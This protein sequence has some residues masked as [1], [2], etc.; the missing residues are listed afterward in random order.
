MDSHSAYDRR[1]TPASSDF[2]S[3]MTDPVMRLQLHCIPSFQSGY[4]AEMTIT[5]RDLLQTCD[6]PRYLD[7]L[8]LHALFIVDITFVLLLVHFALLLLFGA[9]PH[10]RDFHTSLCGLLLVW[11]PP[12]VHSQVNIRYG[13]QVRT[14]VQSRTD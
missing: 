4:F 6:W 3:P 14:G 10:F 13:T 8:I 12:C 2:H 1:V 11:T 7:E 9:Y 5:C